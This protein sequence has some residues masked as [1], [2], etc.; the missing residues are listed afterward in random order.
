MSDGVTEQDC[1]L[2]GEGRLEKGIAEKGAT[3]SKRAIKER[4]E[5]KN[6]VFKISLSRNLCSLET[7]LKPSISIGSDTFQ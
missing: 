1:V 5:T 4:T 2:R 7:K 6:R 3:G